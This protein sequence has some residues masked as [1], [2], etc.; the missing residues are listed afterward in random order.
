M[1]GKPT[2]ISN[3]NITAPLLVEKTCGIESNS[4]VDRHS[5]PGHRGTEDTQENP[6]QKD[7][8]RADERNKGIE[9]CHGRKTDEVPGLT[10]LHMTI[11]VLGGLR[12]ER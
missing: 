2:R 12:C 1:E 11:Y 3:D 7:L 5:L 8:E 4:Y 10:S 6:K 9:E